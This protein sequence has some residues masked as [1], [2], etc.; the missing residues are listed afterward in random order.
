[1]MIN[2]YHVVIKGSKAKEATEA[3]IKT[4]LDPKNQADMALYSGYAPTTKA[5]NDQVEDKLKPWLPT[6][7]ENFGKA[8]GFLD[9]E[10]WGENL[11]DV[12]EKWTEWASS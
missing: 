5:G 8:V 12:S 4:A 2:A 6:T 1:M 3:Y 9:D 11:G 10:W 7:E